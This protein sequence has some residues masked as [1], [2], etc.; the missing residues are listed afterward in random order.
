MRGGNVRL[1]ILGCGEITRLGHLP[2][3]AKHPGV[4]LTALVD[5]D[6]NR[7]RLLAQQFHLDCQILQDYKSVFPHVDAIINALPNS[8]HAPVNREALGQ[9]LHVLC[10]KPL[11][12]TAQDA[13]SCCALAEEKGRLL[14][15][16]MNRRFVAS[17]RLLPLVLE[18]KSLG[19]LEEYDWPYGGIFD[20]QSASG[21]Y[22]SR[23][24]AGGGALLDFGVHM[25]DT[26]I[27]W[28]GPV[29]QFDYQDDDWGSGIEANAILQLKHEGQFG[30]VHG[31][32][33]VS[34][35]Y[36]LSNRF[37]I[38][39]NLGQAEIPSNVPDTVTIRRRIGSQE[40]AETLHLPD[41]GPTDTFYEQLDNFVLSIRGAQ[42]PACAGK[43]ALHVIELIE[44]C[45]ANR[46]RIPEPWSELA[47][48][49]AARP[50]VD[51]PS[52]V[53]LGPGG[54]VV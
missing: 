3:V 28:F 26:V 44:H 9:G 19:E 15:V 2:A 32:I 33:R 37:L 39:G 45:Y 46:G 36:P 25:L 24:L 4:C 8:L 18:E 23:A 5:S 12:T 47:P 43:D 40:V 1:A 17:H 10:E 31:Q 27:D 41:V 30:P 29:V 42:K 53:V 16:G 38:C 51:A 13:R 48:D 50:A 14:A 49:A 20:W 52:A 11:A 54:A 34:R 35:T 7:A 21:F 22:F 6:V